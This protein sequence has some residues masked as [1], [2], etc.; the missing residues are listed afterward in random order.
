MRRSKHPR[1]RN[2]EITGKRRGSGRSAGSAPERLK[3]PQQLRKA[4]SRAE[5]RHQQG[6]TRSRE[7]SPACL[8]GQPA[9]HG[10][11]ACMSR[12]RR[13]TSRFHSREFIRRVGGR[14]DRPGTLLR[15]STGSASERLKPPQRL[16]KALSRAEARHEQGFTCSSEPSPACLARL[17]HHQTVYVAGTWLTPTA[18]SPRRRTSCACCGEFI[19]SAGDRTSSRPCTKE[20]GS[21]T[22]QRV[23]RGL[24]RE[25]FLLSHESRIRSK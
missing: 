1:V 16:R 5:A 13:P 8:T 22:V 2:Q 6:F 24:S 10:L 25:I 9:R 21:S 23:G 15:G 11:S 3:P 18:S 14:M 7:P 19:R 4:L 20:S 17:P 12:R